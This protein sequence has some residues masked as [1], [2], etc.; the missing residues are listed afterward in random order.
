MQLEIQGNVGGDGE[1]ALY[2]PT[3][4]RQPKRSLPI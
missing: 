2:C 4:E 1:L 3:G